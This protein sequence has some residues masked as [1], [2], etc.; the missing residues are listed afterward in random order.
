MER[1]RTTATIPEQVQESVKDVARPRREVKPQDLYPSGSTM[2]NLACTD[3][4]RGA[5]ELGTIQTLPGSSTSG[6][7]MLAETALAEGVND[8]RF[9]DYSFYRDDAEAAYNFDTRFLFGDNVEDSVEEPP[10][11]LSNTV[12]QF[13]TN[14]LLAG[15]KGPFIY[16][17][18]T[19]DALTS[20]EELEKEMR[21][22]LAAAKSEEAAKKIAGSYG[23]EKAK[24]LGKVLRMVNQSLKE[25]RSLLIIVQQLR[26]NT[27]ATAFSNP[28]TTSGGEAPFFYSSH[29]VWLN[30]T[31]T[32]KL[33]EL[34]VGT[35]VEAK[36]TKN[37]L[38]GKLRE[39]AFDIWYDYGVDDIRSMIDFLIK[40]GVWK[41]SSGGVLDAPDIGVKGS[42][43]LD[44]TGEVMDMIVT[45]GKL[46]DLK[47]LAGQVWREREESVRLN[48]IPR[49]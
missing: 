25:T 23:M 13:Q 11:G 31:G 4:T 47:R 36:I 17:L 33:N 2:V 46:P 6:K 30:K 45:S 19:L 43:P 42:Y 1:N 35:K 27:N 34:K 14:I 39:V 22:A 9:D 12:Q 15:K 3:N 21:K 8:V 49:F 41:K 44:G 29:Q 48:R 24:I 37:K 16:V 20:D 28:W 40:L 7:S 38:N 5:F 32:H 18:D 10:Q 26:Q